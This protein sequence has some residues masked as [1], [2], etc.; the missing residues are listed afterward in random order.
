M[1]GEKNKK[2]VSMLFEILSYLVPSSTFKALCMLQSKACQVIIIA[3][4]FALAS[5]MQS[6]LHGLVN[7]LVQACQEFSLINLELTISSN[8]LL[9]PEIN[10]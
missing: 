3:M 8:L 5:H 7:W 2:N 9:N 6:D 10:R 4:L 1:S